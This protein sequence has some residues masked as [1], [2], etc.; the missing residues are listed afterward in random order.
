MEGSVCED[1]GR[2][3]V[4]ELEGRNYSCKH[5]GTHLALHGDIISKVASSFFTFNCLNSLNFVIISWNIFIWVSVNS[6]S[7]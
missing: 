7:L 2:L 3:F 6:I 5:C 1:M 4:E